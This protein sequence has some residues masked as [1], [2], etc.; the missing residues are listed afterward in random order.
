MLLR[1]EVGAR[2]AERSC[3]EQQLNLLEVS[4]GGTAELG[5]GAPRVM[6]LQLGSVA[7]MG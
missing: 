2:P 3:A 7:D 6:S 5:A 1:S 4:S